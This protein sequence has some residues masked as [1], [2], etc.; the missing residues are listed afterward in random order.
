M[1]L[2]LHFPSWRF[3]Y[4]PRLQVMRCICRSYRSLPLQMDFR[5]PLLHGT[6]QKITPICRKLTQSSRTPPEERREDG[7]VP[8]SLTS[9]SFLPLWLGWKGVQSKLQYRLPVQKETASYSLPLNCRL[10]KMFRRAGLGPWP[11]NLTPVS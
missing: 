11:S 5:V 1:V 6:L 2:P 8:L 7:G 3:V 10:D 4:I 9:A